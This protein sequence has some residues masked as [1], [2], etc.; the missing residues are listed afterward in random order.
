M[1]KSH[2]KMDPEKKELDSKIPPSGTIDPRSGV[3]QT[4]GDSDEKKRES[5]ERSPEEFSEESHEESYEID[6]FSPDESED[7]LSDQS[8]V[9]EDGRAFPKK[10]NS[11]F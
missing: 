9:S 2:K 7:N 10:D 8:H 1:G 11:I 5:L 4:S 3:E 6:G